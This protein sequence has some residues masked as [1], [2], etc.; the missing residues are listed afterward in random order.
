MRAEI[1]LGIAALSIGACSQAA[2]PIDDEVLALIERT[3]TT[4]ETYSLFTWNWI[5]EPDQA[6]RQEWSA[7]F[8]DGPLH[9]VET[10]RM[11]IVANC[12]QHT[13]SY[14]DV[15]T[16]E[17]GS[18]PRVAGAACGIQA[19]AAMLAARI[20]AHVTGRFGP[21]TQI[22]V[23]DPDYVRTYEV[24]ENGALV[25]ATISDASGRLHLKAAALALTD[26]VPEGI[27]TEKS[28]SVSAVPESYRRSPAK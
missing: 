2:E 17:R 28:L 18:G 19:N 13:G 26:N 27:F 16:G 25:G 21:T 3:R 12:A 15:S 7:E 22:E 9:R 14:L 10:P 6:A 24:A 4:T 11:R 23:R 8:N 5:T 20:T 1:G